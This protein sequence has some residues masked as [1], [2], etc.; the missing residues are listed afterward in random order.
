[1]RDH[2]GKHGVPRCIPCIACCS[3]S[4]PFSEFSFANGR[5]EGQTMR[6]QQSSKIIPTGF[7]CDGE[8]DCEQGDDEAFCRKF[9]VELLNKML[10]RFIQTYLIQTLLMSLQGVSDLPRDF[11]ITSIRKSVERSLTPCINIHVDPTSLRLFVA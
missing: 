10:S 3:F 6:C 4:I 11:L 2:F 9:Y 5:C 7:W 1:M 8:M